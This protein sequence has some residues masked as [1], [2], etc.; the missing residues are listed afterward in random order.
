MG[1]VGDTVESVVR[2]VPQTISIGMVV[3]SAFIIWKG[4]MAATGSESPVV[5]LLSGSME[6]DFKRVCYLL[7]HKLPLYTCFVGQ[8]E[9]ASV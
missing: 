5:V 4:L 8:D 1:F 2:L 9:L 6:P 7:L 3:T